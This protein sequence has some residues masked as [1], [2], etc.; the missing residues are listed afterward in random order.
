MKSLAG[1]PVPRGWKAHSP[2][3]REN[4]VFKGSM[5]M[6]VLELAWTRGLADTQQC[7]K[8]LGGV[9]LRSPYWHDTPVLQAT[10]S[11]LQLSCCGLAQT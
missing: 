9:S 8:K 1:C 2:H 4:T 3:I 10:A 7:S 11:T 5:L 6:E